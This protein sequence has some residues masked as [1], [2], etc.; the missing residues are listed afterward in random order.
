MDLPQGIG[1]W[2]NIAVLLA[3]SEIIWESIFMQG[4]IWEDGDIFLVVQKKTYCWR[5]DIRL[6]V[7]STSSWKGLLFCMQLFF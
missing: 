6:L 1:L 7:F 3:T 2:H 5:E 4:S